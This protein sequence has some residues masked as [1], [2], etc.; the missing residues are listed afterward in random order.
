[1]T[2]ISGLG[3]FL[4]AAI[5]TYG[6]E[7][8]RSFLYEK[9][10][11]AMSSVETDTLVHWGVPLVLVAV[12]LALFLKAG[13]I[14]PL[15]WFLALP[16]AQVPF[17][18]AA[19]RVYEAAEEAG[20]LGLM[21]SESGTPDSKLV[22]FKMLLLV[23]E[24]VRVFGVK[25]PSTKSHLIPKD[26]LHGHEV[27]PAE[28]NVSRLDNLFPGEHPPAYVNV[29]VPRTDLRRIIKIY[30]NEYVREAKDLRRGKWS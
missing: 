7:A 19:T 18:V 1:M 21:V 11:T 5:W 10:F 9:G 3:T 12:G 4:L 17:H 29:T 22:H 8:F 28:G 13:S 27:Y 26:V 30:L 25:P 2:R 20:V 15:D 16:F 6:W 23:D 14:G 24:R